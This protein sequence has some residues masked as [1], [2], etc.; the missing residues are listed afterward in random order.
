MEQ[1]SKLAIIYDPVFLEHDP[2]EHPERP[3]RLSH[4]L[5]VLRAR[6]ILD[7]VPVLVPG[8]VPTEWLTAVH[9]PD[10]VR[11]LE[12]FCASGGG[13]LALDPTMASRRSFEAALVAA[14]AGILAV[15]RLFGAGGQP[16]FALV[17]PP[18]HHALPA[19]A[20]GF[21]LFNNIAIAATYALRHYGVARV[22][23]VD[24]DVHHGNGTQDIFYRD[25]S[26]LF[27][28]VHEHPL[29]P[30][31]GFPEEVGEGPGKGAAIN[32]PLPPGTGDSAYRQVFEQVLVPAARRFQPE[33]IL[34][35]AG[36]DA[37]WRDPLASMRVSIAGFAAL[38]EIVHDLALELCQGRV[39]FFLEGGYDL[40]ALAGSVAAT[41]E[42]LLG[43]PPKDPLGKAPVQR[44]PDISRIL[45][46][47]RQLHGL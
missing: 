30:G 19:Q 2:G 20:M 27:F 44:E 7:T 12:R 17:R 39:A 14:G 25:A 10:Y 38:A 41:C 46:T 47:A 3:Q 26:V 28:S 18:G 42:V 23:I 1:A 40:E 33:A 9:S 43:A 45:A 36:F 35:S 34:V 4:T 13:M 21:C 22:L 15:D 6:G 11:F 29:Y 37:H 8:A 16:S 5:S 32:V 31:S 24:Y